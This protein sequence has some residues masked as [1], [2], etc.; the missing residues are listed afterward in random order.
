M[1]YLLCFLLFAIA[2]GVAG[3]P[4]WYT[5]AL[6]PIPAGIAAFCIGFM[7]YLFDPT[8]FLAFS[9]EM[10]KNA[11]CWFKKGDAL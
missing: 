3:P 9:A 4:L 7:C 10:R 11:A 8:E 5:H 2:V 6:P 1:K